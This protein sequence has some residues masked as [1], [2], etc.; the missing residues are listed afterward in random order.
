MCRNA[1]VY[2]NVFIPFL[3]WKRAGKKEGEKYSKMFLSQIH[4]S[5]NVE[6]TFNASVRWAFPS[7]PIPLS[8]HL[9][10]S[11][12]F[13]SPFLFYTYSSPLRDSTVNVV[14]TFIDSLILLA[15]ESPIPFTVHLFI[16][17]SFPS[18]FHFI[19]FHHHPDPVQSM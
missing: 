19:S 9:F 17:F 12:S 4:N 14:L 13:P 11:F 18:L 1:N 10:I 8:V 15:P 2:Y 6:L 5:V 7:S 3:M 16:S